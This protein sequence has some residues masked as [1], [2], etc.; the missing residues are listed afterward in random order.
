T[1]AQF[2][3]AEGEKTDE[4]CDCKPWT[5]IGGKNCGYHR[6]KQRDWLWHSQALRG[7]RCARRDHWATRERAEGGRSLHQEKRYDGRG[8][9]VAL[10]RSG[11]ALCRR[12]RETWSHRRTLRERG[13][14]YNRTAR[15]G[16]R[17]SFRP[18]FR[19]ERERAVL[20]G[21]EGPSS[22]QRRRLDYPDLFGHERVGVPRV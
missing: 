1:A 11:P 22:L 4:R 5:K 19:R 13:R 6:R 14:G 8:R 20:Y 18:D 7:R 17:G 12:E 9:R 21:A 2:Q 16:Y 15:G 10:G 3:K